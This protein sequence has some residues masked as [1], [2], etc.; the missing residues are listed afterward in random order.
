[1]IESNREILW[2]YKVVKRTK[3]LISTTIVGL[4][5]TKKQFKLNIGNEL[6]KCFLLP[7]LRRGSIRILQKNSELFLKKED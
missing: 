2:F 7:F 3:E 5:I 4:N 1:M 6:Q